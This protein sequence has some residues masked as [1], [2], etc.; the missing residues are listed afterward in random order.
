M[1]RPRPQKNAESRKVSVGYAKNC[2]VLLL[3]VEAYT[4]GIALNFRE[5]SA[6]GIHLNTP[7]WIWGESGEKGVHVLQLFIYDF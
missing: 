7:D 2:I 6:C 1:L 5:A 4:G 3:P